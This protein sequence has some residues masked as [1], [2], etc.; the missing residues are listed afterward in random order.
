MLQ[1]KCTSLPTT[2][3]LFRLKKWLLPKA[4]RGWTIVP[5]EVKR[6]QKR[7]EQFRV[8][9]HYTHRCYYL[10]KF[11]F[12]SWFS[13]LHSDLK[14]YQTVRPLVL[15]KS[16]YRGLSMCLCVIVHF[17]LYPSCV[18]YHFSVTLCSAGMSSCPGGCSSGRLTPFSP[19][20]RW[21][22]CTR[23]WTCPSRWGAEGTARPPQRNP[24]GLHTGWG[25]IL[26]WA[27]FLKRK[28][29]E[30]RGMW[31]SPNQHIYFYNI[32][33]IQIK[34]VGSKLSF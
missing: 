28:T 16:R 9:S 4:S 11:S 14:D 18:C 22:R 24:C 6:E 25:Q 7:K 34:T 31:G 19:S 29:F 15:K 33:Q 5:L 20:G 21:R 23:L 8:A 1:Y 13:H 17:P 30:K 2:S 32:A 3:L 12:T 26:H 10:W 27:S